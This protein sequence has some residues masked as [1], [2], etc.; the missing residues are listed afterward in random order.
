MTSLSTTVGQ[1]V[2]LVLA[3]ACFTAVVDPK[4]LTIDRC[5]LE[6]YVNA[7]LLLN[8]IPV[9]KSMSSMT[10]PSFG[11]LTMM[12]A[13]VAGYVKMFR[14]FEE[15]CPLDGIVDMGSVLV[16]LLS[17]AVLLNFDTVT[18]IYKGVPAIAN[19]TEP[20]EKKEEP[21]FDSTPPITSP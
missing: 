3:I 4:I 19:D 7:C 17:P 16:L 18:D 14:Y 9:L 1:I 21:F 2:I 13:S 12:S 6:Y 11:A 5:K 8:T 15:A 20:I 10:L